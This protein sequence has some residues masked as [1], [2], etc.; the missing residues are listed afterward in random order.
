MKRISAGVLLVGVMSLCGL[1]VA[2]AQSNEAKQLLLNVEKLSQLKNILSDMKKGYTVVSQGYKK[3][4][5]IASGNFSLHEVFLDGLM[6]VSPEVKKYRRVADIIAAQKSIVSEYK[7]AL[8][9]FRGADVFNPSELDYMASVYGSLFDASLQ[10]LEDLTMVITS[11]KLRMSDEERL[12]AI[13]RIFLEVSD[14]LEFLRGFNRE[15]VVLYQQ[16]KKGK[17]EIEQLRSYYN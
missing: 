4:A 8:R 5:A 13:D 6:M 16:K 12:Q 7:S 11:S 15:A 17:R 1:G 3:V 14:K 9:A 10:N 2:S